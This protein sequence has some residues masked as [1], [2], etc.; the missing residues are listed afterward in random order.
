MSFDEELEEEEEKEKNSFTLSD[1]AMK[2]I[3]NESER[4]PTIINP[5][6]NF[7]NKKQKVSQ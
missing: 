5:N 1:F 4:E 2:E 7:Y 3:A 6:P